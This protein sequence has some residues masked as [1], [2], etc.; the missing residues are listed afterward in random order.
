LTTGFTGLIGLT[1]G[2]LVDP[3]GTEV[4]GGADDVSTAAVATKTTLGTLGTFD[5]TTTAEADVTVTGAAGDGV[6]CRTM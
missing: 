2:L 4:A 6:R 1:A 3:G 5:G